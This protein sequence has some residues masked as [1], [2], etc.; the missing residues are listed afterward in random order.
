MERLRDIL[1]ELA[2][3]DNFTEVEK[4]A[5][6]S[7]MPQDANGC[8]I[9]SGQS[10]YTLLYKMSSSMMNLGSIHDH[11]A[12][13]HKEKQYRLMHAYLIMC[14]ASVEVELP[15]FFLEFALDEHLL[16]MLLYEYLMDFQ[17]YIEELEMA[18]EDWEEEDDEEDE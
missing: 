13:L 9:Y 11:L 2:E 18:L 6:L 17:E 3:L 10:A 16:E 5:F 7:A 4:R 1:Q 15:P 12:K 8:N 14:Y